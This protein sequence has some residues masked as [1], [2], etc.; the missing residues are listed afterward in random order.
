MAA[1]YVKFE[2]FIDVLA[3]QG[4]NLN[5][6][7]LKAVLTNSAPTAATD[8]QLADITQIASGNG[9]TTGGEDTQNTYSRSGGTGT[10]NCV[11]ITWTS[12]S[13]GM[14][15]FRYVVIY[16]DTLTGDPLICYFDY[17]SGLTLAVGE[18]FTV[19]FNSGAA[20]GTLFTI[21]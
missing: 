10:V 8:D 18:T 7:T 15:Q 12:A 20:N 1:T 21:A 4:P 19:K 2:A 11:N 17:G 13:A 3:Q 6:D 5:T 9:Y 16:D 14:A